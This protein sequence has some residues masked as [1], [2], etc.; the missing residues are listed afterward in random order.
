[1]SFDFLTKF[2]K[3]VEL[4]IFISNTRNFGFSRSLAE[5]IVFAE[6]KYHKKTNEDAKVL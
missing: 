6:V 1:M 4:F 5:G 2:V 3:I